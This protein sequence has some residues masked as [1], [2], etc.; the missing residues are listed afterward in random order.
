[1][2]I[3]T[4]TTTRRVL[5]VDDHQELGHS[6]KQYLQAASFDVDVANRPGIARELFAANEYDIILLDIMLPHEDGLSLFRWLRE[7]KP[8]PVIFLTARTEEVDR[9]IGLELGAEDY[10]CK[11]FSARELLARINNVIRR[12]P[13]TGQQ[14]KAALHEYRFAGNVLKAR[15]R[16]LVLSRGKVVPLS[17]GDYLLL[18]AMLEQPYVVFKRED[19]L[20]SLGSITSNV[21]DRAI[22]SRVS[23]LRRKIEPD[24]TTPKILRTVWGGGYMIACEV[25]QV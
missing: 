14:P 16:E 1:M 25:E 15:D 24:P 5:I 20:R 18:K 11:P 8:V 23:R 17:N 10:I 4:M 2:Q 9:V 22:D 7:N 12:G 19:L 6:L 3:E 21:F 13:G